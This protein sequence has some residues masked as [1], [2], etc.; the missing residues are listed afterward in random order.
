MTG[1]SAV[2]DRRAPVST[3]TAYRRWGKR[4]FDVAASA[5]SLVVLWP[6]L[7][8]VALLVRGRLGSPILFRQQRPG[9]RGEAFTLLKFRTMTAATDKL[10]RLLPDEARLT[11]FG[12]TLRSASLDELPELWNVLRG[13]MS[14]VGPRPLLIQYLPRYSHEQAKRHDVRPGISGLAQVDGRNQVSWEERF[15]LDVD[16]VDRVSFGLDLR[17]LLRTL[18]LVITRKGISAEGFATMPEFMGQ[19]SRAGEGERV[20]PG[21]A[22]AQEGRR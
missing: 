14:L 4:A 13:D 1:T 18:M 15:R 11:R 5:L 10:G 22:G 3:N 19:G 7:A 20:Q 17:I 8:A 16:Y 2:S 9:L 6:V 12:R 21:P